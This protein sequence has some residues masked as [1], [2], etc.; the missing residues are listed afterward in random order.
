MSLFLYFIESG[1][2]V[3]LN[4]TD[5]LG[6]SSE[7]DNSTKSLEKVTSTCF[8]P[9]GL[10]TIST[11]GNIYCFLRTSQQFLYSS[12]GVTIAYLSSHR[13]L[14]FLNSKTLQIEN[15]MSLDFDSEVISLGQNHVSFGVNKMVYIY[16]ID[17]AFGKRSMVNKTFK[18]KYPVKVRYCIENFYLIAK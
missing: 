9:E 4:M 5:D 17:S 14:N 7:V 11:V 6:V 3:L 18:L 10:L 15:K 16:S 12:N 1:R 2:I 13:Q 8:S